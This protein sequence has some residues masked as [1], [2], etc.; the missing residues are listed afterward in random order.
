MKLSRLCCALSAFA[1]VMMATAVNAA[2]VQY[3]VTT[4]SLVKDAGFGDPFGLDALNGGSGGFTVD[5]PDTGTGS[6][7][8]DDIVDTY[9]VLGDVIGDLA[10]G[11]F[12]T[13][14]DASYLFFSGTYANGLLNIN[15]SDYP[16]LSVSKYDESSGGDDNIA[17]YFSSYES[18]SAAD[19]KVGVL[20]GTATISQGSY[21]SPVPIPNA[22]WFLGSGLIGLVGFRRKFSKS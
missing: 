18:F 9:F 5:I 19:N 3:R 14:E 15:S 13:D 21:S 2:F 7:G 16:R 1:L 4:S 12:W 22:F 6:L 17:I 10:P 20:S 11:Q 8:A